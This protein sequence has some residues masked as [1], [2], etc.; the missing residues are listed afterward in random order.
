[1]M[2]IKLKT[3]QESN[4]LDISSS[5]FEFFMAI[6]VITCCVEM[7]LSQTE[8]ERIRCYPPNSKKNKSM[9]HSFSHKWSHAC[10]LGMCVHTSPL[11]ACLDP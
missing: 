10:K 11:R 8:S 1:M 4:I 2:R 6:E 3:H 5:H 9:N 7:C